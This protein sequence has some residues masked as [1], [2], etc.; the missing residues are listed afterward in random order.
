MLLTSQF[1]RPPPPHR[2]HITRHRADTKLVPH[3]F[4]YIELKTAERVQI[5]SELKL[6]V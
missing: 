2:P 4:V 6:D 1:D 5:L 3:K